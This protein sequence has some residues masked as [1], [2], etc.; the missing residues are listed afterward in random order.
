M[1]EVLSPQML[2]DEA[3]QAYQ[4]GDYAAAAQTYLAAAQSF[5]ALQDRLT[6]AEM[7]NNASVA[8]LKANRAAAALT[9]V[10]GT[11][12]V[13]AEAKDIRREGIAWGNLASAM[14]ANK[15]IPEACQAYE[16]S[17]ELLES[18]GEREFCAYANKSLAAL[19]LRTGQQI[20]ALAR[21]D[22]GL[23]DLPQLSASQKLLKR[24]LSLRRRILPH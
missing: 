4:R 10:D 8:W 5:D 20:E 11:P 9:A 13:F 2:A 12:A 7:R 16:K 17:I 22:A 18:C 14:E 1:S 6:A 3:Q 23:S 15:R 24:L 19:K 21:M